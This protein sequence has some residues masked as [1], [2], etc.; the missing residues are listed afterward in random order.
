MKSRAKQKQTIVILGAG[1]GGIACALN[2]NKKLKKLAVEIII[3]DQNPY[4][5]LSPNLYLA[6]AAES[7]NRDAC[8]NILDILA[9]TKIKFVRD[10]VSYIDAPERIIHLEKGALNF[11]FAVI[12]LGNRTDYFEI[13]GLKER[14][15]PFKDIFDAGKLRFRL[16]KLL[17]QE[18]RSLKLVVG[19]GGYTGTELAGELLPAVNLLDESSRVKDVEITV[20]EASGR[21]LPGLPSNVSDK[22]ASRLE[23]HGVQVMTET[24]IKSVGDA[25]L[26]LS[27][28]KRV[29]YDLLVWTGGVSGRGIDILPDADRDRRGN[30]LVDNY[31]AAGD[32]N[33]FII[34]DLAVF[35]DP[36]TG[37]PLPRT[38]TIAV[39][40]GKAVADN[41]AQII[42]GHEPLPYLPRNMGSIIPV[43]R[44]Y[45]VA[46]WEIPGG[47]VV[48]GKLVFFLHQVIM[49]RYLLHILPATHAFRRWIRWI[50]AL[51]KAAHTEHAHTRR[52][53]IAA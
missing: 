2:L 30:Y 44:R 25:E 12:A 35:A 28:D 48:S 41:I 29:E 18:R 47:Y 32:D 14:A 37:T 13:P 23:D 20:I 36:R 38:A 17:E 43:V 53:D 49:L 9:G 21:L 39:Q 15:L 52:G 50:W 46:D 40:E 1:F 24:A 34:G 11:D 4:H 31:L 3:V 16:H 6:G 5:L 33:V 7:P 26:E 10:R 8:V 42:R 51:R 45:A 27:G 22:V 19:G